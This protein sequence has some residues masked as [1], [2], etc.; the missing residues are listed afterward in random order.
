[1]SAMD[2]IA[3]RLAAPKNFKVV[4]W[5]E[6]GAVREHETE[7]FGQADTHA[8]GLRGKIGRELIS[9]GDEIGHQP[10]DIVK[11]VSVEILP[12]GGMQS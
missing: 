12:L 4:T 10:G 8:L 11:I 1:M 7:T 5:Y 2:I 9:H 6:D 3:R